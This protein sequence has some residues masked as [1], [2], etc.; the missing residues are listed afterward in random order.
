[1]GDVDLLAFS[2]G[3][4]TDDVQRDG[5]AV[6]LLGDLV[7]GRDGGELI[8]V[9]EVSIGVE[10]PLLMGSTQERL[11]L[12]TRDLV[13]R[14]DEHQGKVARRVTTTASIGLL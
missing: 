2:G 14:I 4:G 13:Y 11:S 7:E 10:D 1:M 9:S 6:G 12:F 5:E 3:L 8:D